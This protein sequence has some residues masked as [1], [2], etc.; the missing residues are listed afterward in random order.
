MKKNTFW[1]N[2]NIFISG[3]AGFVGSNLAKNLVDSG[4][5]VIGLTQNKKV[6]SLLFYEKIDKKNAFNRF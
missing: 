1:K 6:D 4:A 3:V 2:K 5:N